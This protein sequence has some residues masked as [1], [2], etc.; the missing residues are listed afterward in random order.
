MR[1]QVRVRGHFSGQWADWF[2]GLAIENLPSGEAVLSGLLSDQAVLLGVLKRMH[3][4][5]LVLISASCVQAGRDDVP[6]VP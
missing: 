3:E 4:L 2:G 5:G 1:C 6:P